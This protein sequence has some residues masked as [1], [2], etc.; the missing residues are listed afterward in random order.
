MQ[1]RGVKFAPTQPNVIAI[2]EKLKRIKQMFFWGVNYMVVKEKIY[3]TR[4][5]PVCSETVK[6]A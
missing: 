4:M 5:I 3:D 6:K 1:K 2:S